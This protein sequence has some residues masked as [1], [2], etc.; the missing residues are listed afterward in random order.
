MRKILYTLPF[1]LFATVARAD[2]NQVWAIHPSDLWTTND[3]V[4]V[5]YWLT[6]NG[7]TLAPAQLFIGPLL[8]GQDRPV[9]T[10]QF[11]GSGRTI[12]IQAEAYRSA[13]PNKLVPARNTG[14]CNT[15]PFGEL[16]SFTITVTP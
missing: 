15:F 9:V 12:C 13:E 3:N 5:R 1:V 11:V 16:D 10:T 4:S 2:I 6:E 7:T 14:L 8:P